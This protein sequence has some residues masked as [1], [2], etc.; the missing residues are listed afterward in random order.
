MQVFEYSTHLGRGVRLTVTLG[1]SI[2]PSLSQSCQTLLETLAKDF[3]PRRITVNTIAPGGV[4]TDMANDVGWKYLPNDDET[5]TW[6]QV[7]AVLSNGRR[8]AASV[9]LRTLLA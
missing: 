4:K 3:G 2:P 9:Y 7:E 8:S 1:A 5:W 6:E